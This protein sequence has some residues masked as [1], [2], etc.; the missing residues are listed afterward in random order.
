MNGYERYM[1]VIEGKSVDL[2][3]RLPILMAFAAKFIDSNYGAFA[4][5]YRVLVESNLK[6]VEFFNFDQISAISDPYRETQGFGAEIEFVKD[7]V[8][9]CTKPPL[10]NTKNLSVLE[11]PEPY[12]SERMLDRIK[13]IQEFKKNVYKKYSILGW[14]EGPAAEAA[15][16]RGVSNFLMDFIM[17]P[18]FTEELMDICVQVGIEFGVAQLKE[19]ADTIGIGDAIASQVSAQIYQDF[20]FRREKQ[21][22]DAIHNA[23]GLVR[24]HICGDITHLLPH[25]KKLGA[26]IV[27][28]DWQVD[29]KEAREKLG[30]DTVLVGN[31]DPVNAVMKSSPEIIMNSFK[32]IYSDVGDPYI[33]GAGCEI[34]EDTPYEN[35]K[36]LCKPIYK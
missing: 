6:C 7:G 12:K 25:I 13:A 14:I 29:M 33:V 21:M 28:L 35:L 15:D 11:K 9:R 8:P 4:S 23:G 27:D 36:A 24:L 34:P 31:L 5:D 22:V 2:I 3:P 20:I 17:E 10:E 1:A 26:D 19:G 30:K 32:Q 18:D 16:L